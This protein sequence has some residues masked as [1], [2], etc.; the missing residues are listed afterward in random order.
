[1]PHTVK[2]TKLNDG[3]RHVVLHVYV[4]HDG[5]SPDLIALPILDPTS[6]ISPAQAAEPAFTLEQ[7]WFD[8]D[9]FNMRLDFDDVV[10]PP[11][12]TISES[13]GNYVDF[14]CFGGIADR[15]GLDGTG[16]LLLS[17]SGFDAANKQGTLVIKLRK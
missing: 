2:I 6:G 11:A 1:M 13:A 12:W 8:L 5:I 9:G 16:K 3:P 14:S 7:I 10:D 4:K 15:S 17:T